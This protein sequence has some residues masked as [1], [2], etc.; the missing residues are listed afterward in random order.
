MA[1]S[2]KRNKQTIATVG[3]SDM[4][5]EM[6]VQM[7]RKADVQILVDIRTAPR[8]KQVPHFNQDELKERLP[9]YGITYHHI[10]ALGGKGRKPI[11][12]SPNRGLPKAWQAYADHMLSEDFERGLMRL[13]A[14]VSIGKVAVFCA[15]AGWE[16][17]HRKFLAD[18]LTV[19]GYR[20]VHYQLDQKAEH[21]LTPGLE[22]KKERLTYP[23]SGEQLTL[24]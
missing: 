14:L 20:V 17:C 3:H 16:R 18:A 12:R 11:R 2:G 24:F 23:A 9:A 4:A 6:F 10:K 19:R 21:V 7:L 15:E 22:I 13:L 8:S 1:E 5:F